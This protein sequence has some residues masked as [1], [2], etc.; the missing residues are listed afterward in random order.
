MPD[1]LHFLLP[2]GLLWLPGIAGENGV[3]SRLQGPMLY[4][5]DRE[6]AGV[7]AFCLGFDLLGGH[8]LGFAN[9]QDLPALFQYGAGLDSWQVGMAGGDGGRGRP[10]LRQK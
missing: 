6:V 2:G 1:V 5:V 3:G 8:V 7:Q 10:Q 9:D 4:P